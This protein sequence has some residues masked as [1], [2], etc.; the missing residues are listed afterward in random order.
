MDELLNHD[1]LKYGKNIV[2]EPNEEELNNCKSVVIFLLNNN[3]ASK[4][5]LSNNQSVYHDAVDYNQ[6]DAVCNRDNHQYQQVIIPKIHKNDIDYNHY[7]K[8]R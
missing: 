5:E 2:Y 1:Y 4:P 3:M 7:E 6:E 8:N